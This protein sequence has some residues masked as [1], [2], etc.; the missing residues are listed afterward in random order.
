MWHLP[1]LRNELVTISLAPK[2]ISCSW[3][4][5]TTKDNRRYILKAF[6][7]KPLHHLEYEQSAINNSQMLGAH[8]TKFLKR[9]KLVDPY[10]SCSISG[11]QIIESLIDLP[12][13]SPKITDFPFPKLHKT[14]WNYR[15][16]YPKDNAYFTFYLC[17]IPRH[18]LF[19]HQLFAVKH[20]LNLTALTTERMALLSLYKKT[21]GLIF[22][23]SQFAQ[24]MQQNN[25][26][27]HTL[28]SADSIRR[29]MTISPS[30][31]LPNEI[32]PLSIALGLFI[33][34]IEQS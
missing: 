30:V 34:G 32:T 14:I 21:R 26:E 24:D 19:Q 15:Y 3:L 11:S 5:T 25:N 31:Q 28:F 13:A 29:I 18:I 20:Q 4:T 12:I 10:I 2:K 6:E 23:A 16:L 1:K 22:R 8:I 17:G 7:E 9:H 33:I 27:L